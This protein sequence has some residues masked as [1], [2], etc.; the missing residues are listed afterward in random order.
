MFSLC[1]SCMSEP[2]TCTNKQRHPIHSVK[3]WSM[4]MCASLKLKLSLISCSKQIN[5]PSPEYL[6]LLLSHYSPLPIFRRLRESS[7]YF[8]LQLGEVT[9]TPTPFMTPK[10]RHHHGL[11]QIKSQHHVDFNP[12]MP[13]PPLFSSWWN[14]WSRLL[15]LNTQDHSKCGLCSESVGVSE[16]P[17]DIQILQC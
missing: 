1:E 17:F 13:R 16:N 10:N 11:S 9:E 15:R 3:R 6:W 2:N 5:C 4:L 8:L 7:L 12:P 14:L